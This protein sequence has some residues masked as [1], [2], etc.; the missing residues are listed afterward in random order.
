MGSRLRLRGCLALGVAV[1]LAGCGHASGER[2]E[3]ARY[4]KT[5]DRVESALSGPLANVTTAGVDFMLA[6]KAGPQ[7]QSASYRGEE[8]ALLNALTRIRSLRREL[9]AAP[10]PAAA[11][12][13]RAM[14]LEL[15]DGQASMTHQVALLVAFLPP[16]DAALTQ[17]APATTR[18]NTALRKRT[19][20]TKAAISTGDA[21]KAA[22][23]RRFKTDV[24]TVVRRLRALKPPAASA[25][26]YRTQLESLEGMSDAAGRLADAVT[27]GSMSR[28][29]PLLAAYDRAARSDQSLAA[30]RAQI[31]AVRAYN[32]HAARFATWE[33]AIQRELRRIEK[34][35]PP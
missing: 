30:Q 25:P 15:V 27:S 11:R 3:V 31:A 33:V 9:A 8:Q 29:Q 18:L 28:V 7:H 5:V 17:V 24:D 10:A 26:N 1:A 20:P 19:A 4:I 12:R 34:T 22:A 16:F 13:L 21:A 6:R 23:L 35:L 32:A 2:A 14:L